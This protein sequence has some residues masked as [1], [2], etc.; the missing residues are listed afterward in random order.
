LNIGRKSLTLVIAMALLQ[1]CTAGAPQYAES[2]YAP[3]VATA[4]PQDKAVKDAKRPAAAR[5]KGQIDVTGVWRGKSSAECGMLI[6]D[7]TR[8][9]AVNEITL[10][11]LQQSAKVS[12]FYK[13]SY[14]NMDCRNG[15]ETG[16][17]ALGTMGTELLQMRVMMPDGSDCI[18][19]GRPKGDAIEGG[20]LCLQGGGL[21]ERG[22][23]R[24]G[25]NY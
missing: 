7:E 23:W 16:K 25:R 9:G 13:C 20:Y 18:F 22:I 6:P 8:C 17:V 12:G 1:R 2:E 15:N 21:I 19:N 11:L 14:G 3:P 4:T 24:A 5:G 10:T